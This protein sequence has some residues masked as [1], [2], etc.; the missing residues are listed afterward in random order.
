MIGQ[1][2]KL[3]YASGVLQLAGAAVLLLCT[4]FI[5]EKMN[6]Q[7]V[8]IRGW[9]VPAVYISRLELFGT[10]EALGVSLPILFACCCLTALAGL[11][12]A[13]TAWIPKVPP[14]VCTLLCAA[15]AA[16]EAALYIYSMIKLTDSDFRMGLS[17]PVSGGC[18]FLAL[19]GGI[20]ATALRASAKRKI[21]ARTEVQ[22]KLPDVSEKIE[23]KKYYQ[24]VEQETAAG[25]AGAAFALYVPGSEPRGVMVGLAGIYAGVEIPFQNGETIRIGRDA[26]SNLIYDKRAPRVSRH[27]CEITWNAQTRNYSIIDTSTNGTFKNGSEDCLPQNMRIVLEVGCTI[28]LGS[29][30]NVFRLE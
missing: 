12:G 22:T 7:P 15:G 9:Q 17:C 24:V 20:A 21:P 23:Q 14:L 11:A 25:Q 18:F 2:K 8:D 6:Y 28:S 26:A 29:D 13:V 1:G 3:R 27:H 4:L 16:A 19:A 10:M 5:Y 30:D